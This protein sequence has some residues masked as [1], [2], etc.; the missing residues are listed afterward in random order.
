MFTNPFF[1]PCST[2]PN[3]RRWIKNFLRT[4]IP[5]ILQSS[6]TLPSRFYIYIKN[7]IFR[8]KTKNNEN[9]S[10]ITKVMLILV[11]KGTRFRTMWCKDDV[12]V[13][14]SLE[15]PCEQNKFNYQGGYFAETGLSMHLRLLELYYM[16][17]LF[18]LYVCT[19]MHRIIFVSRWKFWVEICPLCVESLLKCNAGVV[20]S[21]IPPLLSISSLSLPTLV[22]R[23]TF[24]FA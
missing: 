5:W 3:H 11:N 24:D 21:N 10:R 22:A 9:Y 18:Y 15:C 1:F 12:E 20:L 4:S 17:F 14:R 16:C 23:W 7:Y 19:Y 6:R 13:P 8:L 2:Q